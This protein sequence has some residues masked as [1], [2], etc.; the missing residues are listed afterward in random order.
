MN[1]P[2][3]P[4]PAIFQLLHSARS[5]WLSKNPQWLMMRPERPTSLQVTAAL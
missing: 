3:L 2:H 5:M 4:T 1:H